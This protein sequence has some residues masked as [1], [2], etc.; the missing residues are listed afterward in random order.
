MGP[1]HDVVGKM[2]KSTYFVVLFGFKQCAVWQNTN[3]I[4]NLY[5]M[6]HVYFIGCLPVV[7]PCSFGYHKYYFVLTGH[8][9]QI[10]NGTHLD[11]HKPNGL[12]LS[13]ELT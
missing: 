11:S 13:E 5:A 7:F 1:C 8:V 4:L 2:I 10:D 12:I 3:T 6:E 9:F